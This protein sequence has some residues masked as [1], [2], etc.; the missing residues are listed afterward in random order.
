MNAKIDETDK[1]HIRS[2]LIF[3]AAAGVGLLGISLVG[4]LV[5]WT[6]FSNQMRESVIESFEHEAFQGAQRRADRQNAQAQIGL[7]RGALERY[8]MDTKSFPVTEQGL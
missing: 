8:A 1:K 5:F 2:G 7:L 3:G 6:F 4:L